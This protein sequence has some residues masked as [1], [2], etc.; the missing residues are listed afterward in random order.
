MKNKL[1]SS[2][3]VL[4]LIVLFIGASA[5]PCLGARHIP[6]PN[7][8]F[9]ELTGGNA[10]LVTCPAGDGPAYQYVK[11]TCKDS[12]GI[13]MSGI[14]ANFFAF[15]IA[16]LGTDT[17]WYGTLNCI[18]TAVDPATDANG[19]I[20][21]N[22]TSDSSIY[23]NITIQVTV[24]SITFNDIDILSCKSPD[25]DTNGV[26]GLGDFVV[27]GSDYGKTVWRSD[28]TG[29]GPVSLGDFVTFGRHYGHS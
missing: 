3:I 9:V 25:Y 14:P 27:F 20:R 4:G 26:I 1:L 6:D 13:P 29:D 28:F 21:F 11:V 8:S 17:H 7:L 18:F 12:T 22:V 5:T 23:G 19:E 16:P 24:M 15:T 2:G 10:P